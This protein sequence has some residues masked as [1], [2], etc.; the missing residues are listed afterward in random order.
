MN[1]NICFKRNIF[2]AA[3]FLSGNYVVVF[4][5]IDHNKFGNVCYG[6]I[7]VQK[8]LILGQDVMDIAKTRPGENSIYSRERNQ[9]SV[10][11]SGR[12]E[13]ARL[14]FNRALKKLSAGTEQLG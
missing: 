13:I 6:T 3:T 7:V 5:A 10:A 12:R 2:I 11:V 9:R 4:L 14:H 1:V 8:Q